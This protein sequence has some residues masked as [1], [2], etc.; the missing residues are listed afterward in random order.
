M[1]DRTI[2]EKIEDL[3]RKAKEVE[4]YELMTTNQYRR[5]VALII[6]IM[7]DIAR[8]IENTAE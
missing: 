5:Q 7:E 8:R 3:K 4:M 6:E 2:L 1:V